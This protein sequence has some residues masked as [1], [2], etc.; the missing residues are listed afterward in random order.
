MCVCVWPRLLHAVADISPRSR[1]YLS[2][3]EDAR[4]VAKRS[5]NQI[6]RART[7][8]VYPVRVVVNRGVYQLYGVIVV[9]YY[10]K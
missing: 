1:A 9:L 2:Q 5:E 3:L 10:Y 8:V 4:G 6:H 7:G